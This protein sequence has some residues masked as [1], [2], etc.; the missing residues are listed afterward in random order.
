MMASAQGDIRNAD[1]NRISP[2]YHIQDQSQ[3]EIQMDTLLSIADRVSRLSPVNNMVNKIVDRIAPKAIAQA[4]GGN[5]VIY[6][7]GCYNHQ[8]QIVRGNSVGYH[9]A[10]P[11]CTRYQPL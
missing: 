1:S 5:C 10:R 2:G 3:G 7:G 4:C 6:Y 9:F 8:Q 11:F